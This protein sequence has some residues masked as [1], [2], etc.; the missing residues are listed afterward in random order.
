MAEWNFEGNGKWKFYLSWCAVIT[1]ILILSNF[2]ELKILNEYILSYIDK[3]KVDFKS[4]WATAKQSTAQ[5]LSQNNYIRISGGEICAL[6]FST[7][8]G[9]HSNM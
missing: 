4:K 6:A 3:I 5:V 8:S 2:H 7:V 9:G 1:Q